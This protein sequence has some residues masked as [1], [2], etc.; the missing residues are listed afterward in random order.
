MSANTR[1]KD[2]VFSFL[3]S[4]PDTLREL[5]GALEGITLP[6]DVPIELN[7]L[8][9]VLFMGQINDISF[10]IGNRLVI[11]LEHQSTIN[12]NMPL[13]LLMYIARIY[14]KTIERRNLYKSTLEHIP[15][16]EFIVLYNGIKP[17]PDQATLKL[18]EAFKDAAGL[19]GTVST[20]PDL[21]LLVKVYNINKGHNAEIARKCEKLYGYSFFVDK[22][23][24]LEREMPQEEAMKTAI[25]YC[26]KH[27]I[28]KG[29]LE[30]NSSE[31]FNM[32]LTEWDTEEAKEV[33]FEEGRAEGI[34]QGIEQGR[35]EGWFGLAQLLREGKTLDEAMAWL[36]D[37]NNAAISKGI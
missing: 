10:T 21:E 16:P 11:V 30:T 20:A 34:E 33:W 9:G 15:A 32:L 4:D 17:Y 31:V 22:A 25:E 36:K 29:F 24:E 26:I 5:Y 6:P 12:P 37:Q 13:R 14:E 19:R 35:E 28:L 27:N 3:F 23:R 8:S 18:S 1:Y 7:T 2:S